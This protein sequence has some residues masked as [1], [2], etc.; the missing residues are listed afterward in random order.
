[1]QKAKALAP[2]AETEIASNL[3]LARDMGM[4]GTPSWVIGDKIVSSALPLGELQRAVAAAR[5][6]G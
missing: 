4:T 2:R 3:Q 6:K 5:A 1:M